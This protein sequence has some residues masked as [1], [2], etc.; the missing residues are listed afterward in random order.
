MI[1][2]FFLLAHLFQ[3]L[4]QLH[5]AAVVAPH[6]DCSL[7]LSFAVDSFFFFFKWSKSPGRRWQLLTLSPAQGRRSPLSAGCTQTYCKSGSMGMWIA[8]QQ[9]IVGLEAVTCIRTLGGIISPFTVHL[10]VVYMLA[11]HSGTEAH[12]QAAISGFPEVYEM[13]LIYL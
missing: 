11:K 12:A 9:L 6:V 5:H 10:C 7:I 3:C 1:C 4:L 8:G 13:L 2:Y